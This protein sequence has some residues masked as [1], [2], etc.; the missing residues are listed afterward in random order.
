M[1]SPRNDWGKILAYAWSQPS[2][3]SKPSAV[4]TDLRKD[5]KTTMKELAKGSSSKYQGVVKDTQDAAQHIIDQAKALAG[6]SYIGY[7][8]VPQATGGL[9]KLTEKKLEELISNGLTGLL[10]FDTNPK[11]WAKILLALW[12]DSDLSSLKSFQQDPLKFLKASFPAELKTLLESEYGIFPLPNRP[13]G[14]SKLD[15]KDLDRFLTDEDNAK[16]LSGIF[17]IG[18]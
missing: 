1:S 11:E 10:Q 6:E 16:H 5:P 7:V 17:L 8:P 18:T 4:L 15:I 13:R 2:Q 12:K 3:A 9:E 14:L